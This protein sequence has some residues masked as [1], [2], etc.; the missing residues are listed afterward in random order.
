M[1]GCAEVIC[2]VGTAIDKLEGLL[3]SLMSEAVKDRESCYGQCL[4]IIL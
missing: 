3:F 4:P 2:R 1:I